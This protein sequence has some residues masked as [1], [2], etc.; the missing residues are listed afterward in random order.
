MLVLTVGFAVPSLQRPSGGNIEE[1]LGVT[2]GNMT[3]TTLGEIWRYPVKSL[4]GGRHARMALR[5]RGLAFDRHWMLV[6]G[7]GR[8]LTQRQEPRMAL[9]D[10]ELD[11]G[12]LRLSTTGA[13]DLVLDATESADG[14]G[15]QVRIWD[16]VCTAHAVD[17][18][19]DRWLSG[20]LGRACRLVY[21]PEPNRRPVDPSYAAPG[22]QVGL[23]DGFPLLLISTASL[24]DLN[25]RLAQPLP[26]VRFRPNLVI[27]GGEPYQEDRWRRITIGGIEF[28]VVKPCSRCIIPTIDPV[29]AERS[30]E[31]L[32]TLMSYRR[33]DNKV[34]F[35]QNLLHD[36]LG[37]LREGTPVEVLEWAADD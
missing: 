1:K 25:R 6:D 17:T 3:E 13:P 24:E 28:R 2:D 15:L 36:G 35:G 9:I 31:P 8:F 26:M 34:Y 37:E 11:G 20:F 12:R 33:R 4:R 23:A 21:L 29:T 22:D 16:D 7:E 30:T 19:A 10:A 14:E 18:A 5:P 27:H 32:R